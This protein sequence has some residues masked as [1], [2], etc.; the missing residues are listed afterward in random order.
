MKC[1]ILFSVKSKKNIMNLSFTEFA[2]RLIFFCLLTSKLLLFL[3]TVTSVKDK[4]TMDL[5]TVLSNFLNLAGWRLNYAIT[6]QN[7]LSVKVFKRYNLI[8]FNILQLNLAKISFFDDKKK[9]LRKR[10]T[11]LWSLFTQN[12]RFTIIAL[13][14]M[15]HPI[16]LAATPISNCQPIRL[17]DPGCWYKFT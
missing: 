3:A 9:Y 2:Q 1:Q 15:T 10:N 12:T 11:F 13:T 8:K 5:Y 7:S 6:W 17:L 16:N 14:L 4:A